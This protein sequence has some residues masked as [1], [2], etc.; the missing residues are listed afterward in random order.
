[1][2]FI[3]IKRA[4]AVVATASALLLSLGV[5]QAGAMAR[6][7]AGPSPQVASGVVH[8]WYANANY[9]ASESVGEYPLR[10]KRSDANQAGVICYGVTNKSSQAGKDFDPVPNT[11]VHFAAGQSEATVYVRIVNQGINGPARTARAYMYNCSSGTAVKTPNVVIKLLQNDP[12][13]AV[14]HAN[15]LGY[16]QAPTDGDPL[17]FVKWFVFG[18]QSPAGRAAN[19]L[20]RSNPTW[21]RDLDVIADS[22]G[23]WSF[24]FWMWNQPAKELASTVERYLANDELA[25]PGTTV[26]LST[27]SLVHNSCENPSAIKGMYERWITQLAKGIGNFRVVLYLEE[28]SLVTTPCL[29]KEQVKVRMS[30][31][32]YAVKVLSK[33]PHVLIYLDAD[34]PNSGISEDQIVKML[35]EADVA[36]AQGFAVNSTHWMWTSSDIDWGQE[37]AK[38]L[39]GKHFIVQTEDNGNGPLRGNMCNPPGRAAGPL[40]WDT[41]Y[42]YADG[43]LWY[44]NPGNSD[45][46]C[47][48]GDP[49]NAAFW[50]AYAVGLIQRRV[51]KVTGPHF[52]LIKSS[53]DM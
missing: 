21:A 11:Q 33:D 32:A 51:D 46:P 28:D 2:M 35:R 7:S 53:T 38:K 3:S 44:N 17:Q 29:T 26:Q 13:Q 25:Q 39:G 4:T 41:G 43:F 50:P 18:T 9:D 40:T 22:P 12:L 34:S 27:Y 36:Q 14:D 37:L 6:S 10:I 16:A 30:E 24:R 19:E 8:Y 5:A 1:M 20:R 48:H 31:L 23:S 52:N 42:K 15:P 47:G 45:G 49:P